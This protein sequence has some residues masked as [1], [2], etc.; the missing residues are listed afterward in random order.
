[1]SEKVLCS[2]KVRDLIFVC[3]ERNQEGISRFCGLNI[4]KEFMP[5]AANTDGL[6]QSK[7]KVV[8]KN[9][10]VVESVNYLFVWSFVVFVNDKNLMHFS[11]TRYLENRI[12]ET[13]GFRGTALKFITRER[14]ED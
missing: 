11:Y 9:R 8:R 4:N 10:F 6:D 2:Y 1:M 3:D 13:F 5:T 7:Y 14:K 12:R